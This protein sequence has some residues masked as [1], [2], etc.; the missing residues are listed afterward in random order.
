MKAKRMPILD[1]RPAARLLRV[2]LLGAC[3]LRGAT[4]HA[5]QGP[6]A[7][8]PPQTTP[9]APDTAPG[10]PARPASEPQ[11]A[12]ARLVKRLVERG[13]I[14]AADA[15]ALIAQAEAEARGAPSPPLPPGTKRVT[16]VPEIVKAELRAE[17]EQELR[18]EAKRNNW[19][20]PNAVPEWTKRF[21]LYGDLRLRYEVDNFG[22]GNA[23]DY[24]PD[25]N[26]I[27]TGKPFDVNF[28]DPSSERWL[29]TSQR[30]SR[31]RIR[32]RLGVEAEI[33]TGFSA[34]L[35]LGSGDS[36]TPVSTNQTLGASGGNFSKYQVWLDRAAI[37]YQAGGGNAAALAVFFGR[38]E[39]PFFRTDLVWD[40]NVN[41]D[42]LAFQASMPL[43]EAFRPFLTAAVSPLFNT[44][45]DFAT[46]RPDK[47]KSIDKWL[48]A[49]QVGTDWK[50]S[51]RVGVK[52]G[53]AFYFFD[54]VRG[55][56]SSD[57]E[58]QLSSITCDT[59]HSRPSFAQ[60]GNT[61][62]VIRTPSIDALDAE[63]N[64]GASR[65]QFFGLSSLF[66]ELVGTAR[67]DFLLQS[68]LQL[69][70]ETDVVRNLGF[71]PTE[72][73]ADAVNNFK[74]CGASD[75]DC[76]ENPPYGGGSLG[77]L[78]RLILG[79]PG[80]A[81]QWEWNL[82][83]TYRYLQSDATLDAFTNSEFALGGTNN[84]GFAVSASVAVVDN[85]IA[86]VRWLSSDVVVGP[87]YSID[88]LHIDLVARY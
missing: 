10:A 39:N 71:K 59:D 32:A 57:C 55:I 54:K 38:F 16:Y 29:N 50:P 45:F 75:L 51:G 84:K 2:F 21:K 70:G 81:R 77:Y 25:F 79:T 9:S 53:I 31:M 58:T 26:A 44:A 33:G 3:A 49:A 46:E 68:R 7:N 72:I 82:V 41:L 65:Y 36:S 12:I 30:R 62:R 28:R 22:S 47:F 24:Y 20:Q 40:E 61:Y 63:I 69:S 15:D 35:R 56:S 13:V 88:V 11:S 78:A 64:Q 4:A 23:I 73:A 17:I 37:R 5:D 76:Q 83:F 80:L 8:S 67:V 34:D 18:E 74:P 48:Y 27:N 85:V 60:K 66:R 6:A 14:D 19:A 87:Q 1:Q 52:L 42:G 43:G 86:T